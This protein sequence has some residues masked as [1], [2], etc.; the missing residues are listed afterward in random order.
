MNSVK[1]IRELLATISKS[2]LK[3]EK[4]LKIAP[5]EHVICKK[6]R[7]ITRFYRIN[8]EN[9][10]QY[11]GQDK[12]EEIK[13]LAQKRYDEILLEALKEEEDILSDAFLRLSNSKKLKEL[14]KFPEE[15]KPFITLNPVTDEGY[16]QKWTQAYKYNLSEH[17]RYKEPYQTLK[18][19]LV[20]SKSELIIADRLFLAGI[21]YHYEERLYLNEG[22]SSKLPDFTILHPYTLELYYW[23]H[24]GG[25]DKEDYR[26]ETKNKIE[27]YALNGIIQGKNFITTFEIALSPLNTWYVDKLI[28]QYFKPLETSQ[29]PH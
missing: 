21:P 23:E 13:Q 6:A 4:A 16:I 22:A 8:D 20:K 10:P 18:G 2:I 29:L 1:T 26:L 7:G 3:L 27:L 15:L 28:E 9:H 12:N 19:D 5:R 25:M 24:F 14:E 17:Y 11:L